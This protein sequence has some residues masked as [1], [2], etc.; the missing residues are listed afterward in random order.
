ME[1]QNYNLL[2][3]KG[4]DKIQSA[5]KNRAKNEA[6]WAFFE[7]CLIRKQNPFYDF[8]EKSSDY[9]LAKE[10][11]SLIAKMNQIDKQN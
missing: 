6:Y 9:N 11:E 10:L 2:L 7:D 3:L 5:Y 4:V 1:K 8:I